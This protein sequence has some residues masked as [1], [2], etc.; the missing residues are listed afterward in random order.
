MNRPQLLALMSASIWG[1]I[2]TTGSNTHE[3]VAVDI[4]EK[5]LQE[6][7]NRI[8]SKEWDQLGSMW[9]TK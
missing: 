1:H 6:V 9:L 4:A 7:C 5:L 8:T 2:T 3:A